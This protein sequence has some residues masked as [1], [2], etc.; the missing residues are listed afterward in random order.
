[1]LPEGAVTVRKDRDGW[2]LVRVGH[3]RRTSQ[4]YLSPQHA[5]ELVAELCRNVPGA[6]AAALAA[7]GEM[8]P[9]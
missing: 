7:A 3:A 5:A 8:E 1:M 9:S 4:L 2:Y 6:L